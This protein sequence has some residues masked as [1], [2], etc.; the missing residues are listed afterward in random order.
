MQPKVDLYL[1]KA[2]EFC[3]LNCP[4]CYMFNLR[5]FAFKE[6]PKI[7]SREIVE[8]TANK[9]VA[10]ARKQGVSKLTISLHGG[11]PLLAGIEW[12]R[13]T[14][15]I[16]KKAGGDD[17]KCVFTTQTNGL[18]LDEEWLQF[19]KSRKNHCRHQ[20]RWATRGSRSISRQFRWPRLVHWSG[21]KGS[22]CYF[23]I[24]KCLD[25]CFV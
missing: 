3:N 4:Y 8:V 9:A 12:Y 17:V 13:S 16:F 2:T 18:L 1:L 5:D 14:V 19:F 6:K 25:V 10:L 23:S 21:K 11:E 20:H 7:M 24:L 22:N 15:D